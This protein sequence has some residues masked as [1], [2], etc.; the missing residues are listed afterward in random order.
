MACRS[1]GKYF[2]PLRRRNNEASELR[3]GTAAAPVVGGSFSGLML[4]AAACLL[5]ISNLQSSKSS[6]AT[7]YDLEQF[8]ASF[9]D[10]TFLVSD[11]TEHIHGPL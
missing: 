5:K 8:I 10:V 4:P 1:N 2:G 11:V 3:H 9:D 6:D 7:E